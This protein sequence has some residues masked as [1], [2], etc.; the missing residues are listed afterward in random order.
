M[1]QYVL[2]LITGLFVLGLIIKN[3]LVRQLC[4]LCLSISGSWIIL[5][6]LYRLGYFH[7]QVLLA[8]LMGQSI[9]GIFY[10]ARR[11]VAKILHIFTLPFFLCLTVVAYWA[12][13]ERVAFVPIL[14]F[15]TALWV[16]GYVLLLSSNDVGKRTAKTIMQCCSESD[17]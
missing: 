17:Q 3:T 5:L 2:L 7:N 12:V 14:G 4:V 8:M 10:L 11:H 13:G 6:T 15:L 1:L 9:T 16:I